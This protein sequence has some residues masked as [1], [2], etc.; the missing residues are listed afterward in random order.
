MEK[1]ALAIVIGLFFTITIQGQV[2]INNTAPKATLDIPGVT[3]STVPDGVLIPRFTASELGGKD[4]AYGLA[5]N[6]A[7]VFVTSGTG[8]TSKT[9][10]VTGT[11][12]YYYDN[13][14]SKWKGVGGSSSEVF[15]VTAEQTGD[16]TVLP[17][18]G[19]IKL[20]ITAP[21]HILTLPTTG[22][23]IGKKI[24]VSNIGSTGI[25]ISPILK[26]ANPYFAQVQALGSGI[27]VYLGGTGN[28]SWDWVSGF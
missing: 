15:N 22:I 1:N 9:A 25:N 17:T 12:F 20:N 5:Q 11:G 7:L 4:A 23:P 2:G 10:D 13:P 28:G 24:Y 18:D 3:A 27:L 8:S 14:S 6:G 19:Y 16:Y 26:N 21:G